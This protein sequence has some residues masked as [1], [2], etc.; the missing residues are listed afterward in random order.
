MFKENVS[1]LAI[2][3]IY[4][5]SQEINMFYVERDKDGKIVA[6]HNATNPSLVE[7]KSLMDK[8]VVEFLNAT[9]SWK[10]LMALSDLG[11]IRVVEDLIDIL[12]R[13]NIINFTE[14]PEHAQQRIMERKQIRE[15][16]SS[17]NLLV[18]DVL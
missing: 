6:L 17:H 4:N 12:V 5:I 18:D 9:D 8:E 14:L 1:G 2:N 15:K 11:T 13:K 7:Q 16:I 3:F 10:Q